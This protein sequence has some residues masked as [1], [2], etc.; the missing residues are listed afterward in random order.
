M[1]YLPRYSRVQARRHDAIPGITGWAQI[2]GRNA[3]SWEEK[4]ALDIWY[5]D[6][7]SLALDIRI[8]FMTLARVL[9]RDGITLDGH[10]TMPEFIGTKSEI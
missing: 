10:A 1:E 6:H 9:K 3:L 4:F 8:V 5:V 2:N 7:W